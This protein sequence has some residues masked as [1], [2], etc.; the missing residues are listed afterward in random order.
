[1]RYRKPEEY[2]EGLKQNWQHNSYTR[3]YTDQFGCKIEYGNRYTLYIHDKEILKCWS[4]EAAK[5]ISLILLNDMI[6]NKP[7]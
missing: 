3:H 7:M 6:M 1:M 2:K 5:Q 4:L